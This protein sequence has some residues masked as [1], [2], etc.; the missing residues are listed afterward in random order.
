M[1]TKLVTAQATGSASEA[2]DAL[3]ASLRE[4]LDG[5]DPALVMCFASTTQPL[6]E[7]APR[8]ASSFPTA[9]VLGSSTAGEFTERGDAKGAVAAV[10]VAG[11]FVVH[12]GLGSDLSSGADAAV[13][14]A[15]EAIPA[16]V[17][18]YPHR[19]AVILLDPLA[20]NGEE[21]T[22]MAASHLGDDIRL[23]GGAAGDDLKMSRTTVSFGER[24]E[25]DA[26]VA[27]VIFGREKLGVGV[28][29]GH[30]A[31]SEP[32]KVTR[33]EGGTV[34]EVEGR[35]AWDVWVEQTRDAAA[36]VGLDPTALGEDEV[37]GYLL[38]YEAALSSGSELKIRAPLSRNEDG[39][40]G[41]ACGIPQGAMIRITESVPERQI[42]SARTAARR[43]REQLGQPP[44][45]A[46]VFDC[47]CRNLI[48]GDRFDQA[49]GA[50]VDELGGV[51]IAGFETYG[52]IAL[53]A[54][55]MSGFHNTTT[56]VLAFPSRATSE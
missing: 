33:S 9:S 44:A 36:R 16:S 53:D 5:A 41:M 39:S 47:I 11:D 32:L 52:E 19:A 25:S 8:L 23:A 22:L 24:V 18:G 26:F 54:G 20:G 29:H 42:A 7:V 27:A 37:G 35:P 10:A 40:L 1:H 21:A 31:I 51:P 45:G 48:L 6:E 15:V 12:G 50:I 14:A 56:V 2:S 30:E 28:C 55:D 34:H 4:Q 46:I 38:R 3:V 13:R 49:T 43:A 17:E